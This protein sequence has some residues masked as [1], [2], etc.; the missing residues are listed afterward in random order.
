MPS[1]PRVHLEVRRRYPASACGLSEVMRLTRVPAEVTCDRCRR[2][3]AM[4]DAEAHDEHQR[5]SRSRKSR[6]N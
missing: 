2:T 3:L 5:K 1:A 6:N 4:A